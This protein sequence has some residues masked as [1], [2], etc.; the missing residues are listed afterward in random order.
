VGI[1]E[2]S[3]ITQLNSQLAAFASASLT[4]LQAGTTD[5]GKLGAMK[6]EED[7]IDAEEIYE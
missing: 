6:T 3:A 7:V 5:L 4:H 1:K 2:S